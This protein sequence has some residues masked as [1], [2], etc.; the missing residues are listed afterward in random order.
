L[1]AYSV[2]EGNTAKLTVLRTGNAGGAVSVHVVTKPATAISWSDFKPLSTTLTWLDGDVTPRVIRIPTNPDGLVEPN[3]VFK[4]QLNLPVGAIVGIPALVKVTI[5]PP[6]AIAVKSVQP[7]L[8]SVVVATEQAGLM[9]LLTAA[10][11]GAGLTWFSSFEA[12]WTGETEYTADGADAAMSAKVSPGQVSWLQTEVE[13]PGSLA[14][15][16]ALNGD[17]DTCL[18]LD[19][20]TVMRRLG[21]KGSWLPET[22]VLGTGRHTL[23]WAFTAGATGEPGVAFLDKVKWAPAN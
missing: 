17:S 21:D 19:N 12:P 22:V 13:G 14:F 18:F 1:A 10:L 7:A 5:L 6:V 9:S 15:A 20:G 16:W 23:R 2:V 8:S 4:V 3:E 11:D